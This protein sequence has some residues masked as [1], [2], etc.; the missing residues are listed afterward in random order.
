MSSRVFH[1]QCAKFVC[2]FMQWPSSSHVSK[3]SADSDAV[4]EWLRRLFILSLAS[5][6]AGIPPVGQVLFSWQF[7]AASAPSQLSLCGNSE[8]AFLS[9]W[10]FLNIEI[11]VLMMVSILQ[12]FG[13]VWVYME[14]FPGSF[15]SQLVENVIKSAFTVITLT[16]SK[17][18]W[19]RKCLW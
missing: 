18:Q 12:S 5:R 1:W 15:G 9:S 13:T 3:A 14:D 19:L 8:D 10:F 6:L 7:I 2:S 16:L 17:P 4:S 11:M